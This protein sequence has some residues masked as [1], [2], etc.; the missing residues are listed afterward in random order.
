MDSALPSNATLNNDVSFPCDQ[1]IV[2]P[3]LPLATAIPPNAP[4]G[5]VE[6]N[7]P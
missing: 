3:L 7:K 1:R 5:L 6:T 4:A 2:M